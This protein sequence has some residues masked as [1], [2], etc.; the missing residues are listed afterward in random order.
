MEGGEDIGNQEGPYR[1][2]GTQNSSRLASL[3]GMCPSE[4]SRV[5]KDNKSV[6]L[7]DTLLEVNKIK[8]EMI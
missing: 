5:V 7:G 3:E 1:T 2:E 8:F 6:Q 4:Q